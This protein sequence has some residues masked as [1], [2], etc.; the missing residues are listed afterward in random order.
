M[1]DDETGAAAGRDQQAQQRAADEKEL[2]GKLTTCTEKV[3]SLLAKGVRDPELAKALARIA[4]RLAELRRYVDPPSGTRTAAYQAVLLVLSR[5]DPPEGARDVE[6]SRREL[7]W[8]IAED[9]KIAM[10]YFAP[11]EHLGSLIEQEWMRRSKPD[12][13]AVW[14]DVAELEA[15]RG[16]RMAERDGQGLLLPRWRPTAID[17]LATLYEARMD[18]VRH[19]RANTTL[20]NRYITNATLLLVSLFV[21]AG[22]LAIYQGVRAE[23]A[24]TW[25][26]VA[27]GMVAGGFGS[28][29]T[30]I[31]KLR[32]EKLGIRQ[33]RSLW[34][35]FVAQPM[36]G[37]A[38]ALFILLIIASGIIQV[39]GL[40]PA[41]MDWRHYVVFGL[42]AGSSEP[43][44][45]GTTRRIAA[46]LEDRGQ[47]QAPPKADT[48][49]ADPARPA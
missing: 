46:I 18:R 27:T 8:D 12:G 48:A 9:L 25:M 44:F 13:W 40:D 15:L 17:R 35:T 11:D 43:A 30:G 39:G 10:L 47:E 2:L 37:A 3:R 16:G 31:Y 36:V 20:R 28:V 38:A 34:P 45:I 19:D 41:Q 49:A 22:L 32:D 42:V 14:F 4:S 29:L 21:L 7:A 26:L 6:L 23:P 1:Q 33:L 24:P 5:I